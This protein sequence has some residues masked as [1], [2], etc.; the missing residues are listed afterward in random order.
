MPSTQRSPL[1]PVGRYDGT[2]SNTRE[3]PGGRAR[4]NARLRTVEAVPAAVDDPFGGRDRIVVTVN[5]RTDILEQ[6]RSHGRI[7][8]SAYR[9][10]EIVQAV[11]Q[12]L[13]YGGIGA[14][15]LDGSGSRDLVEA[16]GAK[17]VRMLESAEACRALMDRMTRQLGM[18]DTRL[19]RRV[20]GDR[21]SYAECAAFQGKNGERGAGYVAARCRDALEDLARAWTAEAPTSARIVSGRCDQADVVVEPS[22][23][24]AQKPPIVA[25]KS[26]VTEQIGPDALASYVRDR[27]APRPEDAVK[28]LIRRRGS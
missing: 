22:G 17:T 20:L 23:T 18:M 4:I 16:I 28:A 9:A 15:S 19:L 14:A 5:R 3:V 13:G 27:G 7:S 12:R 21:M 11:F 6:E 1:K 25:S 24:R 8:E 26:D 10:G 2:R